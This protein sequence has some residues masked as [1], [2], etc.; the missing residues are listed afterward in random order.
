M[1]LPTMMKSN[2]TAMPTVLEDDL[3][4]MAWHLPA[5]S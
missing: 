1:P 4:E 2:V 5:G 3:A